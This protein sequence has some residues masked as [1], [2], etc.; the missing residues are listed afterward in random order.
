MKVK[1]SKASP[2]SRRVSDIEF[3]VVRSKHIAHRM[4]Q[5]LGGDQYATFHERVSSLAYL[6][7]ENHVKAL[8]YVGRVRNTLVHQV[9]VDRLNDRR[10]F[11]DTCELIDEAID[12]AKIQLANRA[13]ESVE[14]KTENQC[15]IA[16]AVYGSYN[17][18]EVIILRQMRNQYMQPYWLGRVLIRCYYATSPPIANFIK[19][20]PRSISAA[21]KIPLDWLVKKLRS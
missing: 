4:V 11:A 2:K 7:S 15:F 13:A 8:H 21:V 20:S 1:P 17:A 16:T 14:T 3:V 9:D 5:E 12:Q 18:P 10:R 19:A 6:F